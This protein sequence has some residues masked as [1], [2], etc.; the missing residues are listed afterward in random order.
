MTVVPPMKIGR[1]RGDGCDLAGA[2]DLEEDVF[3]FCDAGARGE[4][5]GD[6]PAR[7]FA[8]EAEAALLRDGV[9]LDDDAV[10]LVAGS[11]SRSCSASSMNLRTSSMEVTVRRVLVDAEAGGAEGIERGGLRGQQIVSPSRRRIVGVRTRGGAGRRCWARV[12]GW[13]R[14]RRCAGWRRAPGPGATRSSFICSKAACG[15]TTSPRTSKACGRSA[16]LSFAAAD[17]QRDAA[18]GADV[19][20]DIF[21]DGAVAARDAGGECGRA[22]CACDV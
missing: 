5:V 14:R 20:G 13:F 6:G 15:R 7:R 10:D 17:V 21:A 4:L 3:E 11:L 19:G 2:A 18:D 9:D 22:I 1:E 8:G 12:C 16:D